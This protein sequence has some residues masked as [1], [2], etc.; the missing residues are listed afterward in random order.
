MWKSAGL[1]TSVEQRC[2]AFEDVDAI[3]VG[4]IPEAVVVQIGGDPHAI[5][6]VLI[7][8]KPADCEPGGGLAIGHRFCAADEFDDVI[9]PRHFLVAQK[10]LGQRGGGDGYD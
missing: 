9:E 10:L 3:D 5:Q 8:R 1:G 7:G 2:R 6:I 4:E